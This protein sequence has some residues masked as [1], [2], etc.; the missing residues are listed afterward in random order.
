MAE[1]A[2]VVGLV[3]SISSLVDLSAKVASRIRDFTS[4]SSDVPETFRSLSTRLPLLTA[5]LQYIQSQAEAGHLPEDVTRA[6]DA[7]VNHTSEQISTVQTSL[8]KILPSDGASKLERALKALKSL[9]KEDKIQQASERIYR[10]NDTLVLYQTTR[11]VDAGERIWKTLSKLRIIPP[12]SC[13]TP[14]LETVL[15]C[16]SGFSAQESKPR[17]CSTVPFRRDNDFV[18]R[19]TLDEIHARCAQ[20]AARVAL[21]GLGGVG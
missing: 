16:W 20:P 21:V 13:L 18:Y 10:N 17:P 6:L 9:A 15:T 12:M 5:T 19:D 3:A 11:H 14:L 2:A 7:V 1:A 4:K 8:S